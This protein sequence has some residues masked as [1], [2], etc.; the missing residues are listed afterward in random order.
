MSEI[1]A[2]T[3]RSASAW[4]SAVRGILPATAFVLGVGVLSFLGGFLVGREWL[5]PYQLL[6]P[7]V[8]AAKALQVATLSPDPVYVPNKLGRGGAIVHDRAAMAPGV[9]FLT[10]YTREGFEGW[11]VDADGKELHR[12]RKRFSEAFPHATQLIW[13]GDDKNFAW[14]GAH[15]FPDGVPVHGFETPI[16][17]HAA[18][19]TRSS[20]VARTWAGVL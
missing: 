9:T 14:H 18:I 19:G 12:W 10:A 6:A 17:A 7:A 8:D 3:K 2:G 5:F 4:G 20:W 13:Q 16:C 15:L 11:I 1:A